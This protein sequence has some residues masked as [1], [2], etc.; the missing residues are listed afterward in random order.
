VD[1]YLV[2]LLVA[3]TTV[4]TR[5]GLREMSVFALKSR[6]RDSPPRP[7]PPPPLPRGAPRNDMT[8][9]Y[10]FARNTGVHHALERYELLACSKVRSGLSLNDLAIRSGVADAAAESGINSHVP[11]SPS[12]AKAKRTSLQGP[13]AFEPTP[14]QSRMASGSEQNGRLNKDVPPHAKSDVSLP[15]FIIQRNQLFD[16]LKQKCDANILEMEKLAIN[17][18]LDLGMDKNGQLR[19]AMPVAAK[20]W[21]STPGS[22]LKHVEKDVSSDVVIAK[23]NGT[24]LWDLDRPLEYEC[25]VSYIPFSSAEGRNVFWHSSAHVL[26]EACE[27]HYQCRLSHGPPV[28]Q[29]F[30]YDMALGEG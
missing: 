13:R 18:V 3:H 11:T 27:C 22:F 20:A 19:P 28:E 8:V 10:G 6:A 25:H 29:G 5:R 9:D 14:K 21:E 26:G 30:F 7:P 16:E 15:D 23:V 2:Q 4:G 1:A 17:V 12:S 24:E